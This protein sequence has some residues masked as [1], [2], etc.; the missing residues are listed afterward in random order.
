MTANS[1]LT[2][3]L[4][5]EMSAVETYNQAIE[6]F[7]H[8]DDKLQLE[9]AR[10]CHVQR[11]DTLAG[12]LYEMGGSP[13]ESSGVWGKFSR[14]LDAGGEKVTDKMAVA[15]LEEGEERGIQQ[16]RDLLETTKAIPDI[17]NLASQLLAQQ[18]ETQR[19]VKALQKKI[20]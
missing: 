19:I 3:I 5:A 8:D 2:K 1:D 11:V 4:C 15:L 20:G 14:V 18:E 9:I 12:K 16:Y 17:Q 6:T 10:D 7:H 13:T